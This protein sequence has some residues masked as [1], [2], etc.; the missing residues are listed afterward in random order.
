M[1][2][3]KWILLSLLPLSLLADESPAEEKIPEPK[4][5]YFQFSPGN[6]WFTD[7]SMREFYGDGGFTFRGEF[8]CQVWG[9]LTVWVDGGYFQKTGQ[10]IGGFEKTHI[11]LATLTL[12]L[13]L[14]HSFNDFF[15]VYA[16]AGPRLFMMKL[17][18]ESFFVRG[19]DNQLG[20]GGGFD[21]GFWLFP[22]ARKTNYLRNL[23]INVLADYS[24]KNL[25]IEADEISSEDSDVDVSSFTLGAGLGIKF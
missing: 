21:G 10:A 2:F 6:L 16:G 25:E 11:M 15:A 7:S 13:K 20:I 9:P 12:G 23:Y 4:K 17:H 8:G 22:F 24:L 14:I 5:W 19:E 3:S 18:N 1:D